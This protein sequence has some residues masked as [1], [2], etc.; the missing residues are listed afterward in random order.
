MSNDI[1]NYSLVRYLTA[2]GWKSDLKDVPP[3][4]HRETWE[5]NV[6]RSSGFDHESSTWRMLWGNPAFTTEEVALAHDE[7]PKPAR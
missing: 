3:E 5:E 6:K 7:F 4:D 2:K 1:D